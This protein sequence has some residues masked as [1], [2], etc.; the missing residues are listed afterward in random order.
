VSEDFFARVIAPELKCVRRGAVK[1]YSVAEL[2]RWLAA[3]EARTLD[4]EAA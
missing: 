3:N 4:G 2:Q 1:L